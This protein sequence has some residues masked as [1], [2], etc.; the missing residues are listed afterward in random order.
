MRSE[1]METDE[2]AG[3][4]KREREPGT[5]TRS[6]RHALLE[7][8]AGLSAARVQPSP[9]QTAALQVLTEQLTE[10]VIAGPLPRELIGLVPVEPGGREVAALRLRAL[11]LIAYHEVIH[12][13]R[14]CTLAR[15]TEA[16][17]L[18]P[19]MTA[20]M[21]ARTQIGVLCDGHWLLQLDT[22]PS[23]L[24]LLS[25]PLI[26]Y[27]AG[28]QRGMMQILDEGQRARLPARK[29]DAAVKESP[30]KGAA[31]IPALAARAI[32]D[33]CL[34]HVIGVDA[35]LKT[36]S[37]RVSMH[38]NRARLIAKGEGSDTP[39]ECVL[40]IGPSGGGKTHL[41]E[42]VTRVA[43][44]P[45]VS[46]S[47]TDLTAEG[48]VGLSVEQ[49]LRQL[50]QAAGNDAERAR[51]GVCFLDEIDKKAVREN[52]GSRDIS[53]R[54][55]QQ[56]L[57]RVME[58]CV[59]VCGGGRRSSA[60]S[61]A[62][63]FNSRGTCFIF[64]GAFEGLDD[65]RRQ[66]TRNKGGLGF[67]EEPGY[68]PGEARAPTPD[69]YAALQAYGMI[70]EFL[71]RLTAIVHLPEPDEDQLRAILHAP[72]GILASLNSELKGQGI[73]VTLN[74]DL[75]AELLRS[76]IVERSF[77]RGLKKRLRSLVEELVFDAVQGDIELNTREPSHDP[78][79]LEER[80]DPLT[81][82]ASA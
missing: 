47:A 50:M 77:S 30:P 36:V 81:M 29:P 44:L 38:A 7:L 78:S 24:Y 39:N 70:P 21:D 61:E 4:A 55:V 20:R 37:T 28:V 71:N 14:M 62:V 9:Q 35:A 23:P 53:G 42:R 25:G 8:G 82:S 22:S 3:A 67:G 76:V 16:I 54:S 12:E 40:V 74:R 46:I 26:Q 56:E 59:T 5:D 6:L 10:R 75:E 43:G 32:F 52:G 19:R 11:S 69:D 33:Q 45:S 73:R 68:E 17:A 72:H 2:T 15:L 80:D 60:S 49:V 79:R 65:V 66:L 64:A 51:Y 41:I 27:F 1:K 31:A 13:Q 48:Y 18:T 34:P 63:S 57:L 58:G